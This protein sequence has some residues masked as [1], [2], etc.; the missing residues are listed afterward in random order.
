MGR[1]K[2]NEDAKATL[3]HVFAYGSLIWRPGFDFISARPARIYGLH[4]SFC[5]SSVHWRGSRA[6]PGLVLGL[7]KGGACAG[8]LY[9]VAAEDW[10]QVRHYLR[11]REQVTMVYREIAVRAHLPE[12]GIAP[13]LT[14]AV[15]RTHRQY[16]GAMDLA[17]QAAIIAA[18]K[19]VG[20]PNHVYLEETLKAL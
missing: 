1:K 9:E 17:Q 10:P 12:G 3:R 14:F 13:A 6:Q 8:V 18:A 7:D 2:Q 15:D 4:R 19:G 20:G 5:V 16:A 11:A